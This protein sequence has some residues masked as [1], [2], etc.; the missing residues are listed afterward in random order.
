MLEISS[1]EVFP[2]SSWKEVKE[3]HAIERDGNEIC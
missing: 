1:P 3:A 2:F